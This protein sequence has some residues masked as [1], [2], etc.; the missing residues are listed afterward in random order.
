MKGKIAL[1]EH[2]A[3]EETLQDS[4]YSGYFQR[5]PDMRRCL[6]DFHDLR[7]QEMDKHGI[8]YVILALHN[9]AVQRIPDAK[10]AADLA[11]R[12]NDLLADA[13]AKRPDR[14]GGFA[15]LPMQ[16]PDIAIAELTRC[17][18]ELGFKGSMVNGFSQIGDPETVVYLDDP[19][20]L[21]FW[22]KLEQFNVPLYLHPREPLLSHARIYE[23][24]PWLS[25]AAWGFGVETATHA[26]RLMC[27]G[28]F[29]RYPRA[30]VILG[31]LGEGLPYSIW[32]VDHW[33]SLSPSGIPARRKMIDYL[34]S[35]FYI[36]TSGNFRTPAFIDALM[37]V[38]SERIL[39]SVDYPFEET[40]EAV[41]WFDNL[42]ISEIDLLKIGR[43]NAATL[44]KLAGNTLA[45]H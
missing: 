24:H 1:E 38:G 45:A 36:T 44:F 18:K 10:R 5:W 29:D 40:H 23:G 20:Y 41:E 42:E 37:E 9:P 27:N 16:D 4:L 33:I 13:I 7:L 2:F 22:A 3:M 17:V 31:H 26:L 28:L 6:L 11:R 8:E 39:F 32:R 21:P 30:T 34:R 14:F 19:R 43:T 25:C 35:N 12:A 15:A